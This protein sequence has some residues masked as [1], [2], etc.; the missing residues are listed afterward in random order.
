[1]KRFPHRAPGTRHT[2]TQKIL[3]TKSASRLAVLLVLS[4]AAGLAVASLASRAQAQKGR[5]AGSAYAEPVLR[6]A[7]GPVRPITERETPAAG[8]DVLK[9]G[10]AVPALEEGAPLERLDAKGPS[11]SAA[12]V[13][14]QAQGVPVLT[15]QNAPD[16]P[17]CRE[18]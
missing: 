2:F 16:I 15:V 12:G 7:P 1:M 14:A 10:A 3:T 17:Q 11:K 8:P 9:A 5:T 18:L 13:S 4:L 6:P